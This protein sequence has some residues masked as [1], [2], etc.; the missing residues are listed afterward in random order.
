MAHHFMRHP[1]FMFLLAP[2]KPHETNLSH[3]SAGRFRGWGRRSSEGDEEEG[4]VGVEE[5]VRT[6]VGQR[7]GTVGRTSEGAAR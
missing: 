1:R 3:S 7:G 6:Q 4:D 2:R 5:L